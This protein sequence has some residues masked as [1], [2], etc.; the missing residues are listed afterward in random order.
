MYLC[1]IS[2]TQEWNAETNLICMYRNFSPQGE[3]H[4]IYIQ[5][6]FP[7]YLRDLH[8]HICMS[9]PYALKHCR[10][11][12]ASNPLIWGKIMVHIYLFQ[13]HRATTRQHLPREDIQHTFMM[14]SVIKLSVRLCFS[15]TGPRVKAGRGMDATCIKAA[16]IWES[17]CSGAGRAYRFKL[18]THT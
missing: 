11:D 14:D 12:L 7:L 17:R 9:L 6:Y 10:E 3:I 2:S 18:H 16:T 8:R 5:F 1:L 15:V 4:W 13:T